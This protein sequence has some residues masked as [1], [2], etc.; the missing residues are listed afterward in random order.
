[1]DFLLLKFCQE[2]IELLV[3]RHEKGL[4][5]DSLPV[6]ILFIEIRQEVFGV[7]NP[8]D[9]IY[10]ILLYRHS[11]ITIFLDKSQYFWVSHRLIYS[12]DI[13]TRVHDC[14]YIGITKGN[15]A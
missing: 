2:V 14:S 15:N 12:R 3:I 4:T 5:L 9:I 1:M 10:I 11:G 7:N 13:Y 6:K 8:C